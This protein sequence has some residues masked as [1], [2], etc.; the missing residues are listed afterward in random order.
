MTRRPCAPD[1]PCGEERGELEEARAHR[2]LIQLETAALRSGLAKQGDFKMSRSQYEK[3]LQGQGF[4][5]RSKKIGPLDDDSVSVDDG[6]AQPNAHVG[7][8]RRDARDC[9]A[10]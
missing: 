10:G 5:F 4:Q 8:L 9:C 1:C 6:C 3:I 2:E 7:L